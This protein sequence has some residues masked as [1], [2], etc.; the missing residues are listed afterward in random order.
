MGKLIQGRAA[1]YSDEITFQTPK[2]RQII[3]ITHEG[4][5]II[6]DSGITDGLVLVN[7]MHITASVYVNDQEAGLHA[8]LL[9]WLEHVA[10][11]FGLEGQQGREYAH[12]RTGEDNADAH[13]KRQLLGQQVTL[14]LENGE[15]KLGPWERIHY[16]EFDG[17]RRKRVLVKIVGLIRK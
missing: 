3:P 5:Q 12:N 9:E 2:R 15:L 16:A 6:A 10:P 7:P 1:T 13:L 17:Q 11:S 4:E 8:D 14:A